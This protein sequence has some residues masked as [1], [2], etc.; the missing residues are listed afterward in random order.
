MQ[1]KRR[2]FLGSV[3]AGSAF[4]RTGANNRARVSVISIGGLGRDHVN[5]LAQ[6]ER[7]EVA[8]FCDPD[9]I[10][11]AERAQADHR[12]WTR[13]PGSKRGVMGTAAIVWCC[14]CI[15]SR[16]PL[17]AQ[18]G[19]EAGWR[20]WSQRAE[21]APITFIDQAHAHDGGTALAVSGGGNAAEYGG[22]ERPMPVAANRW[23][24]LTA[25]Y[26]CEGLTYEPAQVVAR[27]DWQTAQGERV[28]Q[29]DY[30]WRTTSEGAWRHVSL[31]APAPSNAAIV[32]IQL[33]LANAPQGIVWWESISLEPIPPPPARLA[34]IAAINFRPE[35]TTG[36]PIDSV[37]LFLDA[38]EKAVPG[39]T[40]LILLPEGITD[41]G[42]GKEYV[43]VAEP[44]PGP[45]TL[46][47]GQVARQRNCYF[48]A[49]IYEREGVAVYNTAVLIDRQGRVAG[50]Y[51][52]VYLAREDVEGG[53]TPGNDFPVFETDFG[54]VGIMICWDQQYADPARA[55]ALRGAELILVPIWG[56]NQI[57]G[58]A[59]AIEN[60]VFVAS[61]GYDYPSEILSPEGVV[62]AAAE[63]RG[64]A[65]I[66]TIELGRRYVDPWLGHMRDRFRKELRLDLRPTR[67][68]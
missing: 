21:T 37:K 36:L 68:Q 64:T 9:E 24:R 14:V 22:W 40:D 20:T 32:K 66:A 17:V 43:E 26:R 13:V 35:R 54:K 42:T 62:L 61:S 39:K 49:G 46:L 44:I 25:A 48:V 33:F 60:H 3:V 7:V 2:K 63:Q 23:Y 4:A 10:R 45:T 5:P 51:R 47:L 30:A 67:E 27:L 65:A 29:P 50:K 31:E 58:K 19:V 59:R 11:M 12:S 8:T 38:I 55:L 52:K 15:C 56:G 57:L 16:P 53:L 6:A 34:V 1:W 18:P 41:V 28:G